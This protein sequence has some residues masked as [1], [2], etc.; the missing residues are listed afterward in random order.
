MI[1]WTHIFPV[2]LIIGMIPLLIIGC[3]SAKEFLT[4][5]K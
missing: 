5:D 2:I 4:N 3:I 1:F